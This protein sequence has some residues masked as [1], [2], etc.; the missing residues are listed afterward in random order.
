MSAPAEH[1]NRSKCRGRFLNQVKEN[2]QKQ[3]VQQKRQPAPP[4]EAHL[5]RTNG[6]KLRNAKLETVTCISPFIQETLKEHVHCARCVPEGGMTASA[7]TRFPPHE[8]ED[9]PGW[10]SHRC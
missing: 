9:A 6:K 8:G 2:D 7:Q 3:R 1:I 10:G 5:A 4:G